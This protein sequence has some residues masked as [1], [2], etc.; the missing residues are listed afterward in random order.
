MIDRSCGPPNSLPD[1][2]NET[3]GI[4]V[5]IKPD[6]D[7]MYVS[8][9]F[10]KLEVD[11]SGKQYDA[12]AARDVDW[13]RSQ[14]PIV[15]KAC[16]KQLVIGAVNDYTENNAWWPSKCPHCLTGEEADPMLFWNATLEGI[17]LV[18]RECG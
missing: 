7:V 11:P 3:A 4:D 10:A 15:A 17:A 8:P 12:Y 6:K 13:Y 1:A 18:Q 2:C 9:A 16:P 14:F 5:G